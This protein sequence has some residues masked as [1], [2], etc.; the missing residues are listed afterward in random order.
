MLG[1]GRFLFSQATLAGPGRREEA[2]LEL[3]PNRASSGGCELSGCFTPMCA[4]EAALA[5][6][7]RGQHIKGSPW[8]ARGVSALGSSPPSH[9]RLRSVVC[10]ENRKGR[11]AIKAI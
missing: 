10:Q 1:K 3:M 4:G 9:S 11:H 5:V 7:Y 6:T 8:Q 2:A